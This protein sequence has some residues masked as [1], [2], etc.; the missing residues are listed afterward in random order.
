MF[1]KHRLTVSLGIPI[2]QE[3]DSEGSSSYEEPPPPYYDFTLF[4][5]Q[6]VDEFMANINDYSGVLAPVPGGHEAPRQPQVP[7]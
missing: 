7:R 3:P 4:G 5:A 6:S 1:P 2:K